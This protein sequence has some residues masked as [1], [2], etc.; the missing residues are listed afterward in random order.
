MMQEMKQHTLT[1]LSPEKQSSLQSFDQSAQ[2]AIFQLIITT[3]YMGQTNPVGNTNTIIQN[4]NNSHSDAV[5]GDGFNDESLEEEIKDVDMDLVTQQQRQIN[6]RS[7]R[8][9]LES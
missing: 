7:A 4:I 3:M 9:L 5:N 8:L 2:L 6:F 1:V